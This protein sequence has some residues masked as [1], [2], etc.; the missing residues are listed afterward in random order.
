VGEWTVGTPTYHLNPLR[1]FHISPDQP[2]L[3]DQLLGQSITV[4]STYMLNEADP[5]ISGE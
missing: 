2:E 1:A 4:Y 5:G 3:S